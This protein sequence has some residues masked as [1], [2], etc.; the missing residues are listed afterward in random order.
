MS[1]RHLSLGQHNMGHREHKAGLRFLGR[2]DICAW[3][4]Q[5]WSPVPA[6]EGSRSGMI[7]HVSVSTRPCTSTR[8]AQKEPL[9]F[10][11]GAPAPDSYLSTG[12]LTREHGG[13][14]G[15]RAQHGVALSLTV[16]LLLA[17]LFLGTGSLCPLPALL[18]SSRALDMRKCWAS[19]GSMGTAP[20]PLVRNIS[21][22][23]DPIP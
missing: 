4:P 14:L 20:V 7:L 17:A 9:H 3:W 15:L 23:A 1:S 19:L 2:R 22:R 8:G 13:C 12:T 11:A 10:P 18:L 21:K 5:P 16:P 6:G